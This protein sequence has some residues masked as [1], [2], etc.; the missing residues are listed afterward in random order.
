M[1]CCFG[2]FLIKE[3]ESCLSCM[4]N[5]LDLLVLFIPTKYESNSLKNK[6]NIKL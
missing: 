3:S 2:V 6:G 5:T 1:D 4:W